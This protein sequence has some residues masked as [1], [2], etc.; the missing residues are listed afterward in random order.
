[1]VFA[2][3]NRRD[4]LRKMEWVSTDIFVQ[5]LRGENVGTLSS[6]RPTA[7]YSNKNGI[8]HSKRLRQIRENGKRRFAVTKKTTVKDIKVKVGYANMIFE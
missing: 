5:L 7:T 4:L 3:P 1:M 8:R 2:N 6:H